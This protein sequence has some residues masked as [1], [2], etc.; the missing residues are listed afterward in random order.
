MDYKK[1]L[2]FAFVITLASQTLDIMIHLADGVAVHLPYIAVK[3]TV[4]FWTLFWFSKW[5]GIN[6]GRGTVASF[7]ASFF[8]Y[9]YY[10]LAEPT[11][12]RTIFILDEAFVFMFVHFLCIFFPYLITW[13][14]LLHKNNLDFAMADSWQDVSAKTLYWVL[15][16]GS[17]VGLLFLVPNRTFF[18]VNPNFLLGLNYND[19]I[20]IGTLALILVIA[21]LYKNI[22]LSNKK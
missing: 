10:R 22:L 20:L 15:S 21:S 11:L 3:S 12:D 1:A 19:H 4:I 16:L 5:A 9:I 8:F 13:K 2:A 17:V 18:K 6:W 14:W 7:L